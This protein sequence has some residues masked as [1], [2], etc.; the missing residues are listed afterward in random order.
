MF[1]KGLICTSYGF[2]PLR[3]VPQPVVLFSYSNLR[4]VA[5]VV[6]VFIYIIIWFSIIFVCVFFNIIRYIIWGRVYFNAQKGVPKKG[7]RFP[8]CCWKFPKPTWEGHLGGSLGRVTW[9]G[10]FGGSLWR[11]TL[12][13]HFGDHFT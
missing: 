9:E 2:H 6:W 4:D 12:E 10:H 8:M 1:N 5:Q 7:W 3:N 11:V 13:G